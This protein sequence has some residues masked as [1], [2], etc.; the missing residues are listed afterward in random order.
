[1]ERV[2]KGINYLGP[3]DRIPLFYKVQLF[4]SSLK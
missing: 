4:I 1:M 2:T 3:K